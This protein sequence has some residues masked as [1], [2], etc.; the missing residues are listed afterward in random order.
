M[1]TGSDRYAMSWISPHLHTT[2][3]VNISCI[4][5]DAAI[6]TSVMNN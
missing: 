2:A 3:T 6:A 5:T 1:N 4:L